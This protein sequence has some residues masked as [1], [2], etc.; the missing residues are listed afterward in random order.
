MD[1]DDSK[2]TR[3]G[4]VL[5]A[6]SAGASFFIKPNLAKA[7]ITD[8]TY[9]VSVSTTAYGYLWPKEAECE[10]DLMSLF[11]PDN[12][13]T[14]REKLEP[15]SVLHFKQDPE[16]D[17]TEPWLDVVSEDGEKLCDIP[18][19]ATHEEKSAVM[20]IVNKINEN[21]NVWAEVTSVEHATI[22]ANCDNARIHE[23]EFDVFYC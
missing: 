17:R 15:G 7:S 13:E 22:D 11:A 9:L 14:Q 18:W 16:L 10:S 19:M 20:R 8:K 4:F 2:I 1:A 21:R 6:A 23:L 5:L 3:R 12:A